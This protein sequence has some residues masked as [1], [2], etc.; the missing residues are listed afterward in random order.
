LHTI[1]R[2][3]SGTINNIALTS[4]GTKLIIVFYRKIELWRISDA[5]FLSVLQGDAR[6]SETTFTSDFST[7][8][9]GTSGTIELWQ[10]DNQL[11]NPLHTLE[12]HTD[13]VWEMAF[14]SDGT[15]LA[16]GSYDKTVRLWRVSDGALL[17]TLPGQMGVILSLAFAPNGTTV[18]A[19]GDRIIRLWRVS[20][21]TPL[22][23]LEGH[24]GN[25]FNPGDVLDLAFSPDGK[26]LAS[27]GR[28][29]TVRIWRVSDGTLLRTIKHGSRV[30]GVAFSPDGTMLAS[31]EWHGP[32]RL[33]DVRQ[34]GLDQP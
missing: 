8:A 15:A 10:I 16:S 26:I 22:F 24:K 5:T 31:A 17:H 2:G 29:G 7:L 20:D 21:G 23:T 14:T 6:F 13:Q 18:A 3:T 12:G 1:E 34:W 9:T 11:I 30:W 33:F 28:D 27:G 32:V 4:D 25:L 19:G